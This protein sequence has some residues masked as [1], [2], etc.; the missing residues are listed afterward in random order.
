MT[1][2]KINLLHEYEEKIALFWALNDINFNQNNTY[3]VVLETCQSDSII[4]TKRLI[5]QQV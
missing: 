2:F 3:D 4:Y 1:G 5:G